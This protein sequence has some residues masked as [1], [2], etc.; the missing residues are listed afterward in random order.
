L[1]LLQASL[2]LG[3][4]INKDKGILH[5]LCAAPVMF[6]VEHDP[7]ILIE[8]DKGLESVEN[9]DY[10]KVFLNPYLIIFMHDLN[11]HYRIFNNI[12]YINDVSYVGT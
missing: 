10:L 4:C 9:V 1:T 6:H 12:N 8:L 7:S 11:L 2:D 3:L 5:N